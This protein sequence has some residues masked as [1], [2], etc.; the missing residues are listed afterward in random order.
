[1]TGARQC[2]TAGV[3]AGMAPGLTAPQLGRATR[4][5]LRRVPLLC[6]ASGGPMRILSFL[7]D[8]PVVTA[9]LVHLE[10]PHTPPPISPARGPPQGDFLL[11]QTPAFDP[12]EAEPAPDFSFDQS[13][14]D[15]SDD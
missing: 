2:I 14:P 5:H 7:T 4:S 10:F 1:M 9:I 12:T 15:E 6:P 11:D 13:L 3:G 8:P